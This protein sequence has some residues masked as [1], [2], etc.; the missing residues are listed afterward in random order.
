MSTPSLTLH[1]TVHAP[2]HQ[3][4]AVLADLDHA[5]ER[6]S[7]VTRVQ[8][9]TDGPYAVGTRWRETRRMFGSEATEEMWVAENDPLRSTVVEAVSGDTL[10][11]TTFT[12][13]P[14]EAYTTELTVTF[15][16]TAPETK[17]ARR[18]VSGLLSGLGLRATR[19]MM[20]RDLDDIAAAAAA[21]V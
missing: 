11:R 17:G 2:V 15:T 12:L 1:R 9:L 19:R 8:I 20:E 18:V 13:T 5:Q 3:V 14:V 10:Y 21:T 4:W 16:A 6:L 7:G